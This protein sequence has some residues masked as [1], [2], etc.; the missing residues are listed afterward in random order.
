MEWHKTALE[1]LSIIDRQVGSHS[2]SPAEYEILRQIIQ[3]TADYEYKNL[4]RFSDLSLETGAGA[5]ANRIPIIVDSSTVMAGILPKVRATFA[6]PVFC[7]AET[8]TRPQQERSQI[9][10]GME[11]LLKRYPEAIAVVGES[12]GAL[13]TVLNLAEQKEIEP[14]LIIGVPSNFNPSDRSKQH[15]TKSNLAHIYTEGFKGNAL[16]AIAIVNVLL[17]LTWEA[18]NDR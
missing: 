17:D 3:A 11:T 5:I 14:A 13:E 4:L 18:Q 15:L 12:A 6:N 16:V 2:F 10:W 1:N 8:S 9:D 7:A